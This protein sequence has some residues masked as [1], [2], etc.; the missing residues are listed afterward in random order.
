MPSFFLGSAAGTGRH[1]HVRWAV[2]GAAGRAASGDRGGSGSPCGGVSGTA[3][4]LR[5]RGITTQREA[6]V[7]ENDLPPPPAL[8]G[9]CYTRRR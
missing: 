9:A 1:Q 8:S 6:K 7:T 3:L 2:G 4:P 5:V